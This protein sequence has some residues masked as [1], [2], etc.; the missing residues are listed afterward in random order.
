MTDRLEVDRL[1]R[2]LYAARVGGDLDGVC[3]TFSRDAKL[4]IAGTSNGN[5]IAIPAV[6]AREIR[7]WLALMIKSFQ[8][9]DHTIQ[10]IIID[11]ANAA[12][13]WRTRVYSRITGT[14]VSTEL[15]DMVKVQEGRIA[16][17]TEFFVSR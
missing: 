13:H 4:R 3:R 5:P 1:L 7:R 9:T 15:I 12:V 10:S 16:A 2:E 6:G 8:L 14:S 11:G 17:Y